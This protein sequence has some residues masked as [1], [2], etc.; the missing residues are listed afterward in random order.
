MCAVGDYVRIDMIPC[1]LIE[2]KVWTASDDKMIRVVNGKNFK[3]VKK[4]QGHT[5]YVS[6]LALV[7]NRVWSGR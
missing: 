6:C 7:G 4:L 2:L 1:V 5:D 3:F